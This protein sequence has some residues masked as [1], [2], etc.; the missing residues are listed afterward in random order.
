MNISEGSDRFQTALQLREHFLKELPITD[1][2]SFTDEEW[3]QIRESADT[4][5]KSFDWIWGRNPHT[6]ITSGEM[7]VEIENGIVI[8][9]SEPTLVGQRYLPPLLHA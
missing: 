7:M 4:K 1:T 9:S 3:Q 5:F 8:N 2:I 6:R